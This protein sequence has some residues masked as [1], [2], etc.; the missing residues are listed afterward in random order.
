MMF[1]LLLTACGAPFS[2]APDIEE[3][4][5]DRFV[6]F[7]GEPLEIKGSYSITNDFVFT[8][9]VQ[10]AVALIDMHG[11][12]TR[13][14]EWELPVH[15]Q[16]LGYMTYDAETLGGTFDLNLPAVPRG[17]FN[18]VDNNGQ[19]D[20]GVQIFVVGYSPNL[21]GDPFMA[22]DDRLL[23]WPSYLTS[24]RT[25]PGRDNEVI[26]GML[27]VWAPDADQQFPIG[28]GDDD[29]L[30]TADDPAA[31]IG[32]GYTIVDLDQVPFAFIKAP[33]VEMT[34]YEPKDAAIKDFSSLSYT[35]AFD[36]MFETVRR[37]YAFNGVEGKEPDWDAL[38]AEL[39]PRVEKAETDRDAR[40]FYFALRDFT[41]AFK[42]GHVGFNGGQYAS[43][44]FT[45]ATAGGYG[46]AIRE[47]DNGQAVVIYVLEGGPAA[48]M[49]MQ[50]GARVSA[51]N[52]EPIRDAIGKARTYALQ[53]SD[54]AMRYQ[55]ARY[56]LRAGVGQTAEV[57]FANPGES[58]QT[59]SLTAIAERQSFNRTSIYFGVDAQP[60]LP[61]DS[62]I[63]ASGNASIGYVRINSNFDDLYLVIRLFE[64]ALQQF[65]ARDVAGVIID[66]RYNT[67]G[68]PLGLAGFLTDQEIMLGQSEYFSDATGK[69][70]PRGLPDKVL[71]NE[72]QYLFGKTVLLVGQACY[73]ACEF[74]AYA[75]SQV[76][77]MITV[78]QYPT[79]G[80]YAEVA[81]GQF[82]L[83]EGFSLQVPTGRVVLAD[84]SIF[85]EGQ[86]VPPTLRV[87]VDETTVYTTEDVVLQAGIKAVLEPLG[88]GIVPSAPPKVASASEAEAALSSGANFLEDVA[89]ERY[90]EADYSAPGTLNFTVVLNRSETLIWGYAWCASDAATLEQNFSEIDLKFTL[91]GRDVPVDAFAVFNVASGGLQCRLIYTA[92]SDWKGGEHSL[93]TAVTFRQSIND[94]SA[95]YEAG[96]YV[97]D[98]KVYVK[99]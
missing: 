26:G 51:F 36:A 75:F 38:Y 82:S 6:V 81:R 12:V 44:D 17:E 74:E 55:Q 37:E 59:V 98:Y 31:P 5:T 30:F 80:I 23:G 65:E 89:R 25:D 47:L 40:A 68:A 67:G 71:P 64:R 49:G 69:F 50:V 60:I 90:E 76:P 16:A 9:Y 18:D 3:V 46:F 84:G 83:P 85:L 48:Q 4:V 33:S 91:N 35:A 54:F 14:R 20:A 34:L 62:E 72:N 95:D 77:G 8:Y 45:Q 13:D 10:N 92:L 43:E 66:M 93:T 1:L 79:A 88:A 24:A 86:G 99:P 32:A 29:L 15:S 73:S 61:V 97:S 11:F 52:G 27:V 58:E 94:G 78:G 63:I 39:K 53:S 41:W 21:Y 2:T 57:T 56:L 87:P 19:T 96:D 28:F 42:D 70:E 22:G 7:D